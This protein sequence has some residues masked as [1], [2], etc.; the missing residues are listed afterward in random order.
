VLGQENGAGGG[1]V[2]ETAAPAASTLPF[3]GVDVPLLV[4]T[5]AAMLGVGLAMHRASTARG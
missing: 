3:T 4:L 5:G 2:V 1:E